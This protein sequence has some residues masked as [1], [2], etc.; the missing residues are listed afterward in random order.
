MTKT[1]MT[2]DEIRETLITAE[3]EGHLDQ[4][5][6]ELLT[7]ENMTLKDED[8]WTPLHEAAGSG[9]LK[10]VPT[11]LLTQQN[12]TLLDRFGNTPLHGAAWGGQL[13]QVPK[14]ILTQENMTLENRWGRTPLELATVKGS[15]LSP[16]GCRRRKANSY[17]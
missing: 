8:G 16:G 14:E 15:T 17:Q 1:N 2:K 6:I 11:E 4:V 7:Q 13:D 10:Q 5:P 12:M 3:L 9:H